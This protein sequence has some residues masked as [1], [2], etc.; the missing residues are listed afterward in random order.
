MKKISREDVQTS[1][2]LV[3][4]NTALTSRTMTVLCLPLYQNCMSSVYVLLIMICLPVAVNLL[5][6]KI[7]LLMPS[8]TRNETPTLAAFSSDYS[9]T[10]R[11]HHQRGDSLADSKGQPLHL[12]H[13]SPM[14]LHF[15][16]WY[17][18]LLA[19]LWTDQVPLSEP[20][21]LYALVLLSG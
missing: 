16:C 21:L 20:L 13:N 17:T 9:W 8:P 5:Y 14:I 2:V 7:D 10:T 19:V 11:Q 6:Q 4:S 15:R 3:T 12:H 1:D 18:S